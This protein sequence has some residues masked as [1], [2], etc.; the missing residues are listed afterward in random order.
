MLNIRVVE[1][2]VVCMKGEVIAA[3]VWRQRV[4]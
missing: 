4:F 1:Q 2:T 3:E